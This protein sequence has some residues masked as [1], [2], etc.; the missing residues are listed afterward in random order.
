MLSLRPGDDLV[1]RLQQLADLK[2]SGSLSA[3]EFAAAK[4][5]LLHR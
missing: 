5:R 3:K 2:A 1:V 4:A